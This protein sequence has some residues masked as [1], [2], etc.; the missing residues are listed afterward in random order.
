LI[1]ETND[2]IKKN[3]KEII[4][5]EKSSLRETI[6]SARSEHKKDDQKA[7]ITESST[8]AKPDAFGSV[9]D[10]YAEDAARLSKF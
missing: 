9:M 6:S 7:I 3:L 8:V 1:T 10:R 4:T 5:E 2:S